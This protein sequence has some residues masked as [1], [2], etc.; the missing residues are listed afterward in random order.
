MNLAGYPAGLAQKLEFDQVKQLVQ[1]IVS[2][3]AREKA[4]SLQ[5]GTDF[6]FE[7]TTQRSMG[8]VSARAFWSV[9]ARRTHPFGYG[10]L[11]CSNWRAFLWWRTMLFAIKKYWLTQRDL[12]LSLIPE[13]KL[14]FL[15]AKCWDSA[16]NEALKII[17]RI[18][19]KNGR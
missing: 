15:Y 18:L 17:E 8:N 16:T 19:D 6:V 7:Q 4:L 14:S 1:L 10:I 3:A 12:F 9:D 5:P 13:R 11:I 2:E